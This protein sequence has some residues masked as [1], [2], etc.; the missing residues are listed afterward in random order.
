MEG[1]DNQQVRGS[2]EWQ[3]LQPAWTSSSLETVCTLL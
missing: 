3:C 2:W 1:P